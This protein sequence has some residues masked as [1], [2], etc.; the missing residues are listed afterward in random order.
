MQHAV[1]FKHK[2]KY[3]PKILNPRETFLY[4]P[5]LYRRVGSRRINASPVRP[6]SRLRTLLSPD[7]NCF[8]IADILITV[9]NARLRV[10]HPCRRLLLF[11]RNEF[12]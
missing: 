6:V 1:P 7:R 5:C 9:R 12:A 11:S 10:E 3:A 2:I 8:A 4:H